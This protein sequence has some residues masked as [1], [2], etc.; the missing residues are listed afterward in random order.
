MRVS[1]DENLSPLLVLKLKQLGYSVEHVRERGL[2]NADD[3]AIVEHALKSKAIIITADLDFGELWYWHYRGKL[4]IIVLRLKSFA[5][6]SQYEVLKFLH[7][8][9][10]LGQE[11]IKNSLIMSTS[12]RYRLRRA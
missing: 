10:V 12:T 8:S 3:L 2:K 11:E 4:G 6:D 7:N 9:K 5:L 1:I